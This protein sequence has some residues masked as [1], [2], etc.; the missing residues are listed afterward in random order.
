MVPKITDRAVWQQAEALMQPAFIRLVANLTQQLEQSDWRGDYEDVQ[1]WPE[2]T[3]DTDKILVTNLRSQLET[4]SPLEADQITQSLAQLPVPFPGHQLH[5][6]R[7]DR[8]VSVDLWNL[9][10]Q[11]CFQNYDAVS[12]TSLP[13]GHAIGDSVTIDASLFDET[14]EV[15]WHQLDEKTRHLVNQIFTN[16]PT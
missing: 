1:I 7:G 13:T 4:A 12:G 9:C 2:G 14:G 16:L 11:I 10:Y 3:S 8:Q 5:L 6:S 15:D